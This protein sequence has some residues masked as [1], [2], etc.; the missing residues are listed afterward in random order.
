MTKRKSFFLLGIAVLLF[1]IFVPVI[2]AQMNCQTY[3]QTYCIVHGLACPITQG[4]PS[5]L[6]VY[7]SLAAYCLGMGAYYG[8]HFGYGFVS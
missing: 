4:S 3:C 6:S 2:P 5:V 8:E 1:V 7:W